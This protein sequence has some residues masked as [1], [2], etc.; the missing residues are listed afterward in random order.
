MDSTQRFSRPGSRPMVK[1]RPGCHPAA[2][3]GFFWPAAHMGLR[4]P[5]GWISARERHPDGPLAPPRW[6]ARVWA[7]EP[8]TRCGRPPDGCWRCGQR[9]L[10]PMAVREATSPPAGSVDLVTAGPGVS[11]VRSYSL[12]LECQRLLKPGGPDC[13]HLGT[14][15]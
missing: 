7:G 1:Y 10:V 9:R 14:I 6:V 2:M 13:P 12:R 15:G 5:G 4:G 8:M 11:L 3:L